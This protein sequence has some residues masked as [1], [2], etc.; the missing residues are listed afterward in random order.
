MA[1]LVVLF[2]ALVVL[3]HVAITHRRDHVEGQHTA[4][5]LPCLLALV[6]AALALSALALLFV[7]T[8]VAMKG[9]S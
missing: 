6:L 9:G 7:L 2:L 1:P 3:A 8:M 5:G 4:G